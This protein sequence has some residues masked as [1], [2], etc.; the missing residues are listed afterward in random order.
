MP[1]M[2]E[3][4]FYII[5]ADALLVV[6]AILVLFVTAGLLLIATGGL[7]GW[8][9]VRNPCFRWAHLL[10]I[11]V[12]VLQSWLGLI[13]PLTTWEMQLRELGGQQTYQSSFISYWLGRLLYYDF[14]HWVFILCYSCFGTLVLACWWWVRPAGKY[15]SPPA[16]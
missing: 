9:W 13:C 7:R 1:E 5:A 3:M 14:P 15:N 10:A 12:V 8:S 2:D 16:D 4:N 11:A 6:H